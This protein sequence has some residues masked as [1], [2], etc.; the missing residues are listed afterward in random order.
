MKKALVLILMCAIACISC[1]SKQEEHPPVI[2]DDIKFTTLGLDIKNFYDVYQAKEL[3][4]AKALIKGTF[5][6]EEIIVKQHTLGQATYKVLTYTN[7]TPMGL[8]KFTYKFNKETLLEIRGEP[9]VI[10]TSTAIAFKHYKVL[11][12][13]VNKFAALDVFPRTDYWGV[14]FRPKYKDFQNIEDARGKY[15]DHVK[16]MMKQYTP[17]DNEEWLFGSEKWTIY[18]YN[19]PL[20]PIGYSPSSIA[21]DIYSLGDNNSS[22]SLIVS[23]SRQI[24]YD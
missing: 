6:S 19:T 1:K 24:S 8:F 22:I 18:D 16:D 15:L 2:D 23:S 12:D 14:I 20:Q 13:D 3:E 10:K 11:S 21:S 17:S 4:A 9:E 5:I 7:D